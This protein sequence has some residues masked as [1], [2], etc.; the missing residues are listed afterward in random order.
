MAWN[1]RKGIQ[2]NNETKS[3][4]IHHV[5]QDF[6]HLLP[7]RRRYCL[8]NRLTSVSFILTRYIP[9]GKEEISMRSLREPALLLNK[10]CPKRS[11]M[12]ILL[13]MAELSMMSSL[14][15]GLG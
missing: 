12:V 10:G 7:K 14:V 1:G 2:T 13:M 5:R 15:A 6:L 11:V 9:E 4:C 3:G 8:I